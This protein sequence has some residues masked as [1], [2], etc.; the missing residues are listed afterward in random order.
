MLCVPG[1]LGPVSV[2]LRRLPVG[3]VAVRVDF[4]PPLTTL[5]LDLQPKKRPTTDR[6][7]GGPL[8]QYYTVLCAILYGERRKQGKKVQWRDSNE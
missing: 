4:A 2:P 5:A 7:N 8:H 3:S 6:P 1:L